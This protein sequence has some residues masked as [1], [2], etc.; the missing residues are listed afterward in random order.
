M[1]KFG[2]FQNS[3]CFPNC[4]SSGLNLCGRSTYAWTGLLVITDLKGDSGFPI[5]SIAIECSTHAYEGRFSLESNALPVYSTAYVGSTMRRR[6]AASLGQDFDPELG[7]VLEKSWSRNP[8]MP[9]QWYVR[10]WVP[11]PMDLFRTRETRMFRLQAR[12]D[13][14]DSDAG[15]VTSSSSGITLGDVTHLRKQK[16]MDRRTSL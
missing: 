1:S 5:K 7:I 3:L 11:V 12:V 10:F 15:T 14:W 6:E 2:I 8:D 4:R 16:D 9:N 13:V